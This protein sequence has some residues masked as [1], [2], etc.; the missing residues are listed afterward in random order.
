M[1]MYFNSRGKAKA[2][3]QMIHFMKTVCFPPGFKA[4]VFIPADPGDTF[5]TTNVLLE[6]E[7]IQL[8]FKNAC[9]SLFFNIKS[10][11]S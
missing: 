5:G 6:I 2:T 4:V 8:D 11:N 3:G 10:M 1:K 7:L 9:I